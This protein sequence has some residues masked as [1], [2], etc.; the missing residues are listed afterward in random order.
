VQQ[1]YPTIVPHKAGGQK[2]G[3]QEF[4]VGRLEGRKAKARNFGLEFLPARHAGRQ[5]V[6]S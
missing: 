4:K 2:A 6:V 3:R 1:G 5:N